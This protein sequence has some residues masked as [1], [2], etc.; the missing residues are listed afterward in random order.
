[1][2][3][4]DEQQLMH[5]LRR[6]V[7]HATRQLGLPLQLE[8]ALATTLL[9]AFWQAMMAAL[10]QVRSVRHKEED[11]VSVLRYCN[12]REGRSR[13]VEGL[14]LRAGER[15]SE[16]R[17]GKADDREDDSGLHFEGLGCL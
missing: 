1:M 15:A 2:V 7:W 3:Q 13:T 10:G 16:G 8:Q 9:Q 14:G 4:L 11:V 12:I 17:G 5:E 6:A